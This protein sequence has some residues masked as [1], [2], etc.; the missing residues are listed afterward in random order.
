VAGKAQSLAAID[1]ESLNNRFEGAIMS[2]INA[3]IL[4]I[5]QTVILPIFFIYM[6][7]KLMKAVWGI[8]LK[9]F[10]TRSKK[11]LKAEPLMLP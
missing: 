2:M 6:L 8:D 1:F 10:V 4:F 3:M 7:S 9:E 5:L 11:E